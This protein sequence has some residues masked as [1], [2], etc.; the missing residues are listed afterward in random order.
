MKRLAIGLLPPLVTESIRGLR[1]WFSPPIAA[2]KYS[3]CGW[4]ET[5]I[6]DA[7]QGW[8]ST[9]VVEATEKENEESF[10]LLQR[11][12]PFGTGHQHNL[13][14][15]FAY[16]LALAAQRKTF[17]SIMDWG[18]GLGYCYHVAKAALPG[19]SIEYHCKEI[20]V[21]ATAGRR[22]IPEV[23]WWTDE[24]CLD[25]LYDVIILSGSLQY[26]QD[27][28]GQLRRIV[29]A[30]TNWLFIT[31]LPVVE[32][33]STYA[34]VQSVYGAKMLHWQFNRTSVL[35]VVKALGFEI[36]REFE[37]GDRP[38]IQGAPEQ[39][40]LRGWLFRRRSIASTAKEKA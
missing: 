3:P 30:A 8:N 33:A 32:Y 22:T 29:Q 10:R 38:Y 12:G 11:G 25:R 1:R 7:S 5:L 18:G 39:C 40:E 9:G 19:I 6:A 36:V 4:D 28:D 20:E 23:T 34:A 35:D 14:V 16:V 31:R 24:T 26:A 15:S 27:W 37:V 21:L 2:L 13:H 17:L